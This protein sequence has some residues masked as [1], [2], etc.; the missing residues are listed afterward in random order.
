M[1]L[2]SLPVCDKL[3]RD[4]NQQAVTSRLHG[5]DHWE[6]VAFNGIEIGLHAKADLAVVLNF[7]LIHDA[8]R[9]DDGTDR[10]HGE[11]A[12]DWLLDVPSEMLKIDGIQKVTLAR[13]LRYHAAG[14]T[15]DEAT[16]GT[17]WDA[18][19]LDLGRVGTTPSPEFFSTDYGAK[20]A[21]DA[22]LRQ[23][24]W[25]GMKKIEEWRRRSFGS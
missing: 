6:R 1:I 18:D 7:A 17:C 12:A 21:R 22:Q 11:R 8:F 10:E 16:V 23:R 15:T 9:L 2:E 5:P 4:A 25:R 14:Y 24:S 3:M 13:A 20:C 19:R